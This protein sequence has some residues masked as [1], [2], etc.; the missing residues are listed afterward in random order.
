VNRNLSAH[1]AVAGMPPPRGASATG[2]Q[3]TSG[4]RQPLVALSDAA[5]RVRGTD[6]VR[7]PE[8]PI[9]GIHHGDPI[10]GGSG[11]VG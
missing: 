9:G 8:T 11:V 4:E 6:V 2:H 1:A 3:K 5:V 7:G 10:A